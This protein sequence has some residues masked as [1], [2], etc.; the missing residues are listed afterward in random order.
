MV[1]AVVSTRNDRVEV[2]EELPAEESTFSARQ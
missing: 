2:K 1:G